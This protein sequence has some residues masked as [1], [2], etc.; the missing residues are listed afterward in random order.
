MIMRLFATTYNPQFRSRIV[1]GGI[2]LA[3]LVLSLLL[4]YA[5]EMLPQWQES[6][7][8]EAF[9]QARMPLPTAQPSVVTPLAPRRQAEPGRLPLP[10]L[11]ALLTPWVLIV[12]AIAVL[13]FV[14]MVLMWRR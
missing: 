1:L 8:K 12:D 11:S 5:A 13:G 4:A 3:A 14:T 7:R 9:V 10:V 6:V 2:A